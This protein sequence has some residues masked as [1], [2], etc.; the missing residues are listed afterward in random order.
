[1][2]GDFDRA[3]AT[4]PTE[5]NIRT[6]RPISTATVDNSVQNRLMGRSA[7][8]HFNRCTNLPKI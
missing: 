5:Q 6:A 2:T 1:L 7:T 4:G 8:K 3:A